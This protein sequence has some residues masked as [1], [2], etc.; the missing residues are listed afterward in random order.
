M[1]NFTDKVKREVCFSLSLSL[2]FVV[3]CILSFCFL[4]W[5]W[6]GVIVL[7]KLM[8]FKF[9]FSENKFHSFGFSFVLVCDYELI[10][11]IMHWCDVCWC[12]NIVFLQSYET[13]TESLF[14]VCF[15]FFR[16]QDDYENINEMCVI[17]MLEPVMKKKVSL[18]HYLYIEVSDNKP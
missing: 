12:F 2:W 18:L 1:F 17:K 9:E 4:F 3:C 13:E 6:H 14:F 7:Q 11:E 8:N 16:E 5:L 10:E 15:V